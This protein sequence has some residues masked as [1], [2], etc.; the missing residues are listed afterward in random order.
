MRAFP[1][2]DYIN[3]ENNYRETHEDGMSLRAYIAIEAMNALLIKTPY[4]EVSTGSE[5]EYK[6]D[7]QQEAI[8]E[9]S[10]RIADL[11]IKELEK[12]EG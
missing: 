9:S 10:V 11:L 3:L 12:E 6:V 7:I 5:D 8:V 4:L 2:S 1:K